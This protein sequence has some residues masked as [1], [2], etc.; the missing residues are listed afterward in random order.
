MQ[1]AIQRI[2][3]KSVFRDGDDSQARSNLLERENAG[4]EGGA[5]YLFTHIYESAEQLMKD[6]FTYQ[7]RVSLFF[8][9]FFL[10]VTLV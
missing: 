2:R 3:N 5:Q 7:Y 9:F 10:F 8:G 1:E 4:P 6:F